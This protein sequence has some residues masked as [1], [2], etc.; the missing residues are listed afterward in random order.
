MK[1]ANLKLGSFF[2]FTRCPEVTYQLLKM[3][4]GDFMI[5][6]VGTHVIYSNP[7]MNDEVTDLEEL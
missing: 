5:L 6:W 3:V 2:Y 7:P 1:L 4:D